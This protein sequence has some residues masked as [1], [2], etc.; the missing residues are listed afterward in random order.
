MQVIISLG[1]FYIWYDD[2]Q[3]WY[4]GTNMHAGYFRAVSSDPKSMNKSLPSHPSNE[5]LL[6]FRAHHHILPMNST[7]SKSPPL[8]YVRL[9]S[10]CLFDF[11]HF[12][13]GFVSPILKSRKTII[14]RCTRRAWLVD[15][16]QERIQESSLAK[17]LID[18]N[19][20][21]SFS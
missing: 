16:E 11:S 4:L 6:T 20:E 14:V 18:C 12:P 10:P 21:N 7:Y 15:G 8:T 1:F 5:T 19:C 9:S 2:V 3:L 17:A 13:H